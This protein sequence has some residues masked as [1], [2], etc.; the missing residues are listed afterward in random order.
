MGASALWARQEGIKMF[1]RERQLLHLCSGGKDQCADKHK[2]GVHVDVFMLGPPGP[3]CP[4]YLEAAKKREWRKLYREVMG[5]TP[6]TLQALGR[7]AWL[8]PGGKSRCQGS[9]VTAEREAEVEPAT[10]RCVAVPEGLFREKETGRQPKRLAI[11]PQEEETT[12]SEQ[13]QEAEEEEGQRVAEQLFKRPGFNILEPCATSSAQSRAQPWLCSKNAS[14]EREQCAGRSRSGGPRRSRETGRKREPD[15]IILSDCSETA[16]GGEGARSERTGDPLPVPGSSEEREA[17]RSRRRHGRALHGSRICS[18][19]QQLG[20]R[21]TP[22]SDSGEAWGAG[23]AF[24][25]ASGPAAYPPGGEG[26]GKAALA[27]KHQLV[28]RC[29]HTPT[30]RR[31]KRLPKKG[32]EMAEGKVSDEAEKAKG[33]EGPGRT[34]RSPK[35]PKPERANEGTAPRRR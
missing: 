20:G 26:D 29:S 12:L 28:G 16:D 19:D 5:E 30:R 35:A 6:T 27:P 9:P 21:S 18:A 3:P 7:H 11:R 34:R 23:T 13:E 15:V 24:H 14:S 4:D 1:S 10:R 33:A 17:G 32:K 2:K 31:G 8:D 25:Y 22:G